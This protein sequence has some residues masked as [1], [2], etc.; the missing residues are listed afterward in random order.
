M[1]MTSTRKWNH[2]DDIDPAE[3]VY[4]GALYT[5]SS[6]EGWLA[7][8]ENSTEAGEALDASTVSRFDATGQ[9][10]HCGARPKYIVVTRHV[11][12]GD[13]IAV[14]HTCVANRFAFADRAARDFDRLRKAA[15]A[16]R[17]RVAQAA[18]AARKRAEF[19]AEHPVEAQILADVLASPAGRDG[20]LVDLA[21]KFDGYGYL[22]EK[23][24]PWVVK[25]SDRERERAEQAANEPP[26][27]PAPEGRVTVRGEI[28]AVKTVESDF[29]ESI[30]L[31]VLADDHYKVW[32]TAPNALYG[33]RDEDLEDGRPRGDAVYRT[34]ERG[35]RIEFAAKL[36]RS[37]RD[38]TF[39]F[40]KRPTKARY[41]EGAR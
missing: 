21:A 14:G 8:A 35:D 32:V 38:E 26:L 25:V 33:Y 2:L 7:W 17:E 1:T 37:D 13:V 20:F 27:V 22:T 3:W 41:L 12:T 18:E 24:L 36:E 23:Q 16:E 19:T 30:K 28:V 6:E 15:A 29:G 4:V 9:C 5:G 10:D 40:G 34:P 31:L 11:P 39:A